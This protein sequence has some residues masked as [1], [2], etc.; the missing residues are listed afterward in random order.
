MFVI[1]VVSPTPS[2]QR[3]MVFTKVFSNQVN[4]ALEVEQ[5]PDGKGINCARVAVAFKQ[6]VVA[7]MFVGGET[8]VW[9]RRAAQNEGIATAEVDVPQPTRTCF[10]ILETGTGTTTEL[11]ESAAPVGLDAVQA[12]LA[13]F[14]QII[15]KCRAVT[16]IGSI[17]PG[18]PVTLYREMIQVAS[19]RHLPS[20]VDAQGE[21]LLLTLQARPLI[22][23]P[24]RTELA[25]TTGLD[26]STATG[27]GK[28]IELLH[29]EG[30]RTVAVTNGGND[31]VFSDGRNLTR[32]TPPS[33][34]P[35]NPVGSGDAM[36]GGIA[37]ALFGGKSVVEAVRF[38]MACGAANAVGSGY[39]RL[40]PA[41]VPGLE[42]QVKTE[43]LM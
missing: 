36:T 22:V 37:V 29:R 4:R 34:R 10:T 38:G 8:G 21:A 31:V 24:N 30:A 11:V 7:L 17:P 39:G 26:C 1:A 2:V 35:Q 43:P 18:A 3:R 19:D 41:L 12:L 40:N 42:K 25:T 6:P 28:A 13:E 9:L 16:C 15:E 33:I 20:V 23:K 27:L 32:L 14:R 5:L